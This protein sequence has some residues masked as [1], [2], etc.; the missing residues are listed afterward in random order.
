MKLIIPSKFS[1]INL[2]NV[3]PGRKKKEEKRN[4]EPAPY[5]DAL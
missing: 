2:G 1:T 4:D 3:R 5:F